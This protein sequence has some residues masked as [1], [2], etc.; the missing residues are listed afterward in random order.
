MEI[1][2]EKNGEIEMKGNR[3]EIERSSRSSSRSPES[4]KTA[5]GDV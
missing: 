4:G 5:S 2:L 1:L 3:R